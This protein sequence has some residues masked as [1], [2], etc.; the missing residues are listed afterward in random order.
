MYSVVLAQ[1]VTGKNKA[2]IE[3]LINLKPRALREAL[4]ESCK[5]GD[6]ELV[7]F[8]VEKGRIWLEAFERVLNSDRDKSEQRAVA[9]YLWEKVNSPSG[10]PEVFVRR[11]LCSEEK[12]S[13]IS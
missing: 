12:V 8:V 1:A 9:D 4:M 5:L 6:L 3:K 10:E 13:K 11:G 7:K 2:V